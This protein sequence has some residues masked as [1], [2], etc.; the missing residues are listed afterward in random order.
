MNISRVIGIN[1]LSLGVQ[2]DWEWKAWFDSP[3]RRE[4]ARNASFRIIRFFDFRPTTP[5]LM[6]CTYWDE[7]SQ[8]GTWDWTNVDNLVQA[9]F[10]IG[11]EPLICF[12]W[13][14]ANSTKTQ[15]N[16]PPGMALDPITE[17]PYPNSYA[18]Y[19]TKWVKHFKEKGWPVRYYEIM[20]E[21]QFYFGWNPSN[22]TKLANYIELWNTT[23]RSM[24]K[25]NPNILISHDAS[26][27]KWVFDYWLLHGDDVDYLDFHKYDSSAIEEYT[28]SQLFILAEQKFF[29]TSPT[30]YGVEEARQRWMNVRGK[31]L[32]VVIS[33]SNLNSAYENGTDPRIQ[34]MPGAV[35][36]ALTLRTAILNGLS[37]YV[38]YSFSSGASWELENNPSGGVGFGMINSDANQPWYPYYAIK[39][40]SSNIGV[41]DALLETQS[42]SD[43]VRFLA[44]NHS[45][46]SNILIISRVNEPRILHF[47]GLEGSWNFLKIDNSISWKTARIQ[48]GLVNLKEPVLLNG[49]TIMLCRIS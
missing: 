26:T 39:L 31:L 10:D 35:W 23:A 16:I 22:T 9:I 14:F 40:F 37:F 30:Y 17:L 36:T 8:T 7:A 24:R 27:V 46:T 49:Y 12:G 28:D 6:P 34:Q 43:D 47:K 3:T 48:E 32:P 25:E 42:L 15:K 19:C 18:K 13:P 20:N 2:L 29:E 21:P 41:G 4:L 45:R 5:R 33:E 44:W 11:A 1:N 38:Y